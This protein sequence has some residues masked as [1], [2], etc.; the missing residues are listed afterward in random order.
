MIV[1][2]D[3]SRKAILFCT[4]HFISKEDGVGRYFFMRGWKT[5]LMDNLMLSDH[6]IL[7]ETNTYIDA[8]LFKKLK[9]IK[10]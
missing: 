2:A 8:I 5:C 1:K 4:R 6:I 9:K 7:E 10:L 3:K